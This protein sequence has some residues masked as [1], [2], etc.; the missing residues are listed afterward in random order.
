MRHKQAVEYAREDSNKPHSDLKNADCQEARHRIRHTARTERLSSEAKPS[1]DSGADLAF[2]RGR[3][4][5]LPERIRQAVMA[6]VRSV[7]EKE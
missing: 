5:D 2:I 6:L 1:P 4:A 3:W 7:P